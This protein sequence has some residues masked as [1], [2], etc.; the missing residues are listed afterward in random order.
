MQR[1]LFQR[2]DQL[3]NRRCAA[4]L[5]QQLCQTLCTG[6]CLAPNKPTGGTSSQQNPSSK[7]PSRPAREADTPERQRKHEGT[8]QG[9][10]WRRSEGTRHHSDTSLS[11]DLLAWPAAPFSSPASEG[12][13]GRTEAGRSGRARSRLRGAHPCSLE[14]SL[15]RVTHRHIESHLLTAEVTQESVVTKWG[16]HSH[17]AGHPYMASEAAKVGQ[18]KTRKGLCHK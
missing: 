14:R 7:A 16:F 9:T 4:R 1:H 11:S 10:C 6:S 13:T 18:T 15:P 17:A 8:Q 3:F 2:D 5:A 12:G